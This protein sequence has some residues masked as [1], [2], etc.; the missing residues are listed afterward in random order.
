[1]SGP[2]SIKVTSD[3]RRDLLASAAAFTNEAAVVWEY[4]ANSL[5]Y[6]DRGVSP[7]VQVVI[8]PRLHQIEVSDNG[9]GMDEND[10][11]RFFFSSRRRHTRCSRDWSSDVCSSD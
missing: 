7:R 1:M 6:I 11:G 8:K 2:T 5:Q 4:V 3:V 9:A 10:L